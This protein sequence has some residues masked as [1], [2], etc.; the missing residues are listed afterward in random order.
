[1]K[2]R[3]LL[4]LFAFSFV[5][6][7]LQAQKPWLLYHTIT[8]NI[9][10][11]AGLS[12]SLNPK[13]SFIKKTHYNVV[14]F[15]TAN[16]WLNYH[17]VLKGE[18]LE[19]SK[20]IKAQLTNGKLNKNFSLSLTALKDVKGTGEIGKTS[21]KSIKLTKNKAFK[22]I[23]DIG[24]AY[25]GNEPLEG[26]NIIYHLHSNKINSNRNKSL[27]NKLSVTFTLFDN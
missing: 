18:H 22:I 5:V 4:F 27:S 15:K 13:Q 7:I 3:A 20:N 8:I 26:H 17:S 2:Y 10:Q 21:N 25:T 6:Q 1:M 12:I 14:S 24:I 9:P 23:D 11:F 19:P 16:L